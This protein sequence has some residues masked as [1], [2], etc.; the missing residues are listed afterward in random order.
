MRLP[1]RKARLGLADGT[2]IYR[3]GVCV[4]LLVRYFW[5]SGGGEVSGGCENGNSPGDRPALPDSFLAPRHM[6]THPTCWLILLAWYQSRL[7][8]LLRLDLAVFRTNIVTQLDSYYL[9]KII[10]VPI[11]HQDKCRKLK[12]IITKI[13]R[14]HCTFRF[15]LSGLFKTLL[16]K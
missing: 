10:Q 11:I 16:Y 15:T 7:H 12:I 5:V 8:C 6:G 14:R 3:W 2:K 4:R 13:R 9:L 1:S